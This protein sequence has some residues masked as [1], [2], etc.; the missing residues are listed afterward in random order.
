MRLE[1]FDAL[2]AAAARDALLA[3]C[4]SP[5]WAERVAAGRPYSDYSALEEA[6]ADAV[7]A[8]P[9]PQIETALSAHPRIGE[10]AGGTSREAVW[11]RGEQSGAADGDRAAFVEAN[12]AYE[13]RFGHV[14][15]IRATGRTAEEM[16]SAARERLGNPEEAE[17]EIVRAELAAITRLRIGKLVTA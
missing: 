15:L 2:T 8:L 17:R 11:S 9:W 10:R 6:A 1:E 14:F 16:L 3:C 4:A 13:D 5:Q 12:K 7:G